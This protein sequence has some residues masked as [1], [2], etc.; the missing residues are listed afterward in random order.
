MTHQKYSCEGHIKRRF[1]SSKGREQPTGRLGGCLSINTLVSDQTQRSATSVRHCASRRDIDTTCL[2]GA[3]HVATFPS[4]LLAA[5]VIIVVMAGGWLRDVVV[6]SLGHGVNNATFV[7]LNVIM[8]LALCALMMML[9]ASF[10]S[11]PAMVPHVM[12]LL[13]LATGLWISI[14]W[15]LGNLGLVDA[16]EQERELFGASEDREQAQQHNKEEGEAAGGGGGASSQADVSK[17]AGSSEA[18]ASSPGRVDG[19]RHAGDVTE[20]NS[21]SRRHRKKRA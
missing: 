18:A 4:A 20:P 16:E 19:D 14:N 11:Y 9:V 3:A 2:V 10:W 5:L 12:V 13:A 15:L 17:A 7:F 6:G 1:D 21:S 8:G